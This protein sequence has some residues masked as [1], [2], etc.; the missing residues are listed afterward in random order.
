M[1]E[2]YKK[3]KGKAFMIPELGGWRVILTGPELVTELKNAP[4]DVMSWADAMRDVNLTLTPYTLGEEVEEAPI[5]TEIVRGPL[6]K[7]ISS[8]F[9]H[10][11][12]ELEVAIPLLVPENEKDS[13]GWIS[14]LAFETSIQTVARLLHRIFVGAP[15][16]RDTEYLGVMTDFTKWVMITATI[17]SLFPEFLKPY[18]ARIIGT[19]DRQTNA[20]VKHTRELIEQRL[21]LKK[22]KDDK[23]EEAP[24]DAI[25][26][27]MDIVPDREL[28]PF[29]LSRRLLSAN[30]GSMHTTSLSTTHTL[31][32]L[33][34]KVEYQE[35][36]RQEVEAAVAE[37][38][39]TKEAIARCVKLD[40]FIKESQRLTGLGTTSMTRR[41]RRDYTFSDGSFVP[42]GT[43]ISAAASWIH[44]DPEYYGEDAHEFDGF[45]FSKQ[46]EADVESGKSHYSLITM[47]P[48]F[49]LWGYGKHACSGRYLAAN[50]MKTIFAYI[51]LNY[52]IRLPEGYQPRIISFGSNR[53]PDMAAKVLL[54][55]R[56]DA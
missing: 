9:P 33:A 5:H 6:T 40:S 53:I 42:A 41:S 2:G 26:W 37:L 23:F 48:E 31:L 4:S 15:L 1:E 44:L 45:R 51:L 22:G 3:Y 28:N 16:C 38:G 12:D 17:V 49:L 35:P 18:V 52:E 19:R 56:V 24:D 7:N 11:I 29:H 34:E 27:F 32:H 14:V 10:I 36:L 39:W 30:F 47:S 13:E 50:I 21:K 43:T 54:R 55:K 20:V 8:F 46:A 25:T